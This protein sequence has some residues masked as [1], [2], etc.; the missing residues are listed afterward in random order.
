MKGGR[1]GQVLSNHLRNCTISSKCFGLALE[2]TSMALSSSGS[3]WPDDS[4]ASLAA[5][6]GIVLPETR[7][8][9]H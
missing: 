1:T 9:H 4:G 6:Q 3:A 8:G 5:Q 7:H 2:T